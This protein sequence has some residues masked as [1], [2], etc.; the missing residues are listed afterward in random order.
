MK[1]RDYWQNRFLLL[2]EKISQ[3]NQQYVDELI[4]AYEKTID[5]MEREIE[6]WYYRIANNNEVSLIMAKKL[7]N[8]KQ[9]KEFKW[10]L[11]DYIKYGKTNNL[12]N[13]WI[14]QLENA[15]SRVHIERLQAM[16]IQIR[17]QLEVLAA[18]Q[19]DV[20]NE[21]S[22]KAFSESYNRTI[23][24]VQKGIGVGT[25]F[26][27]FDNTM[28]EKVIIKPWSADGKTF[29]TR[30]WENQEKLVNTLQ[31][32]LTRSFILGESV[33]KTV[34][35]ITGMFGEEKTV[36]RNVERLVQTERAA[37]ASQARLDSLSEIGV[38]EL[39]FLATLDYKTS[40]IC[41]DM[42]N[43]TFKKSDAKIGVN[44]PPLHPNCRSSV[45]PY[46]E[47]NVVERL[48]KNKDGDYY[49]VPANLSYEKWLKKYG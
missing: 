5:L 10:T 43:K 14:K 29:S 20:L 9:L 2:E 27:R 49:K 32:E 18:K 45:I 35:R 40:S 8:E 13:K 36:K 46:F 15:S 7:L 37:F 17:Q 25:S 6:L 11:S 44:V 33:D 28:A 42:D 22:T 16:Q 21:A 38:N 24:E 41:V 39:Q 26:Q 47:G 1:S 19:I 4:K 23:Y 3:G 30:I 34:K 12:S 48:A 31:S